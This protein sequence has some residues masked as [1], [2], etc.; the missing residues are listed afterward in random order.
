[1]DLWIIVRSSAYSEE[2]Q[3]RIPYGNSSDTRS[4]YLHYILPK[5]IL[6]TFLS[7]I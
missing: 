1:M 2:P 3:K 7:D 6:S 5:K 4:L